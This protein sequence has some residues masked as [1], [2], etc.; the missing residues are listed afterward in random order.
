V[1]C[2]FI[3]AYDHV[4]VPSGLLFMWADEL[5][6][7][8]AQH[9]VNDTELFVRN[10]VTWDIGEVVFK[11]Y[12]G[13]KSR[14]KDMSNLLIIQKHPNK[15]QGHW[16]DGWFLDY[17][18]TGMP[19]KSKAI[20]PVELQANLIKASTLESDLVVDAAAGSF[21]VF[22]ACKKTGRNFLGCDIR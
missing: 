4:L 7:L 3:R 18:S 19:V 15:T 12:N 2:Q 16:F 8:I 14:F 21:S 5:S 22:K 20:K 10:F 13:R 17:Y 6:Y 9:L 11:H 1:L